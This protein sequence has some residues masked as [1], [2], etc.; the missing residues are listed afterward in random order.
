M[1]LLHQLSRRSHND[2]PNTECAAKFINQRNY[3]VTPGFLTIQERIYGASSTVNSLV[4][5]QEDGSIA[6]KR[7]IPLLQG[8]RTCTIVSCTNYLCIVHYSWSHGVLV[9]KWRLFHYCVEYESIRKTLVDVWVQGAVKNIKPAV[10][11]AYT[12][13][14]AAY[15]NEMFIIAFHCYECMSSC[16][17]FNDLNDIYSNTPQ[18][19][20][21]CNPCTTA[22]DVVVLI[23]CNS[24]KY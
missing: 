7:V 8:K 17:N 4:T 23:L 1:N 18:T 9:F 5:D 11:S 24:L 6:S 10:A 15:G 12:V 13:I 14:A 19:L 20:N 3:N 16:R 21:F 22:L 2:S